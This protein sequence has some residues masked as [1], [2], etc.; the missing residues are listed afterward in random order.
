MRFTVDKAL[1]YG[2]DA[3]TV[4]DHVGSAITSDFSPTHTS[5]TG[6]ADILL[7]HLDLSDAQQVPAG[8]FEFVNESLTSSYPPNQ[9]DMITSTWPLRSLAKIIEETPASLLQGLLEFVQDGISVWLADEYEALPMEQ[10]ECDV[11]SSRY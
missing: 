5:S 2:L 9:H 10:Y 3:L 11:R 6:V 1:D 7:G 4:F 8:L